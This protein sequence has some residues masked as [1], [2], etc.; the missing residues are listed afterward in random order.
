M[1]EKTRQAFTLRVGI[2][3]SGSHVLF[4]G[5]IKKK[6]PGPNMYFSGRNV[7]LFGMIKTKIPGPS[8]NSP[9]ASTLREGIYSTSRHLF[10]GKPCTP[11]WYN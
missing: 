9:G 5:I 1:T 8:I 11:F 4:F 10:S 7:L 3:I 2:Y 6:N